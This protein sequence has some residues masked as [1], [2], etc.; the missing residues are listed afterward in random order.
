M[1]P[2]FQVTKEWLENCDSDRRHL[3]MEGFWYFWNETWSD[4]EG[5]YDSEFIAREWLHRYLN[6]L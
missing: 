5:P 6:Q 4:A 3:F 1:D 2:V